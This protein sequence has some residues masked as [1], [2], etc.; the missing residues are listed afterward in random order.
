MKTTIFILTLPSLALAGPLDKKTDSYVSPLTQPVKKSNA[1][2]P[3]PAPAMMG[4]AI[5]EGEPRHLAGTIIGRGDDGA[6]VS[7]T[8][9]FMPEQSAIYMA[10]RTAALEAKAP[11][12]QSNYIQTGEVVFVAPFNDAFVKTLD[13]TAKSTGKLKS[14]QGKEVRAFTVKKP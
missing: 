2:P 8:N 10:A 11:L 1:K 6:Y 13:L 14:F 7:I 4:G 5:P 3:P 12:P 9:A